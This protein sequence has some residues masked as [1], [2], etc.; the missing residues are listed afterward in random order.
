VEICGTDRE[1]TENNM[2]G[3]MRFACWITK[4]KDTLKLYNTYCFSAAAMVARTRLSVTFVRTV[5]FVL[6]NEA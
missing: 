6:D 4:A 2:I 1:T 3:R 5:H